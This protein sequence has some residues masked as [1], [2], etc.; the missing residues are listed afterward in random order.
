MINY[1]EFFHETSFFELFETWTFR[2]TKNYWN[3]FNN[4]K[5]RAHWSL[6]VLQKLGFSMISLSKFTKGNH[7][8]SQFLKNL[9]TSM[10][11]IF[12]IIERISIIFGFSESSGFKKLKKRS[13]VE[14]LPIIDHFHPP[15]HIRVTVRNQYPFIWSTFENTDR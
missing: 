3:P 12:L 5:Y 13:F 1:W 9:Q 10:S 14:K 4:K 6:E 15:Y 2:K 8:K 7:G 11:S